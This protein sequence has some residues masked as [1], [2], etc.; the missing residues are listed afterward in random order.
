MTR[1]TKTG[2]VALAFVACLFGV[3]ALPPLAVSFLRALRAPTT[4]QP[5]RYISPK[6]PAPSPSPDAPQGR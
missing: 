2:L 1:D 5:A 4:T 3:L 6:P